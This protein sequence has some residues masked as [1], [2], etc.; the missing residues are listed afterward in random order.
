MRQVGRGIYPGVG[1]TWCLNQDNLLEKLD[2]TYAHTGR[3]CVH[4]SQYI[5]LDAGHKLP[6]LGIAGVGDTGTCK[7]K[8]VFG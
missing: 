6:F 3:G 7:Y 8:K 1:Y 4:S 2:A 5:R